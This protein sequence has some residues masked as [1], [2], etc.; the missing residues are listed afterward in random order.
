[1][2]PFPSVAD[3]GGAGSVAEVASA[4]LKLGFTAFGGPAA[5]VAMMRQEFVTRRCWLSDQEFLDLVGLTNLIPGPNSTETAIHL[6]YRRA[7]KG[8]L[9][10][11][12]VCFICPAMLMV[13]TLAWAY[14][15]FGTLP[16][17]QGMLYGMKPVIVAV[18]VQA[19]VGL[20]R[21]V[22][23]GPSAWLIAL[24]AGV[25]AAIGAP[26]VAIVFVPGAALGLI[27]HQKEG[28]LASGMPLAVALLCVLGLIAGSI[29]LAGRDLGN[30]AYSLMPMFL[31]FLK[32]GAVLYGGGYVLLSYLHTDLVLKLGWLS[33]AQLLDAVAVGQFTPGPVF[34]TAT[35]VGY[36]LGGVPGALTATLAIFLPSFF[37]V[38]ICARWLEKARS[39]PSVAAFLGGVNAASMGLM[40][41]VLVKLGRDAVVDWLTLSIA[42]A[43]MIVLLRT[44]LNSAWLVALGALVGLG[45]I[46]LS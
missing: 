45:Y 12:G 16:Q 7:G 24:A 6:G 34:T 11:A 1:M 28:K 40:G 32:V 46:G 31:V 35:F 44:K 38:A 2:P 26:E 27:A 39:S 15:R 42:V 10:A 29:W 37:F 30:V 43:S 25:L 33:K 9:I 14:V 36:L 18:I 20:G 8:G 4:F 21:S 13:L 22:L 17:V 41:A 23:K 19:L 3:K 5:H